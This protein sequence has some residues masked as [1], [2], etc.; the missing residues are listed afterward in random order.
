MESDLNHP[1]I[2]GIGLVTPLGRSAPETWNALMSGRSIG[3]HARVPGFSEADRVAEMAL[4]AANEALG[5]A[6]W[7]EADRERG[8]C[9]LFVGTS[10][11][12]IESWCEPNT[13]SLIH[14][15]SGLEAGLARQLK[16]GP[17]P[18][19]TT[20]SACSSG[21]HA[22]VRAALAI[23]AREAQRVLVVAAEAS[24]QPIFISSFKRLGVLAPEGHGCLPFDANRAGFI[25]SEAAAAICLER[26]TETNRGR[27]MARVDRWAIGADATHLTSGDPYAKALR[28][29]FGRV[30]GAP[31]DL[32]HA[33]AT[34]TSVNDPAEL[35]AIETIA[36]ESRPVLYSHK[37]A[38][39][40]SLGA[41]GLIS[42]VINCLCHIHGRVPANVRST[43]PL[44]MKD[45]QFSNNCVDRRISRS[46]AIAA[47]FGGPLAVVSC[48]N[49]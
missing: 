20:S 29:L 39:G 43:S 4:L 7:M 6:G 41:A 35:S 23:R 10:K 25:I 26:A 37:A 32:I 44:P 38:L 36:G 24:V 34:G 18:R 5:Q 27:V 9:G 40:H 30:G 8:D 28:H 49:P 45:L 11:G 48:S 15:L 22:L 33:H 47:G 12:E 21:L 3:D 2:T 17:G 42:V 31:F 16:F 46:L 13:L 1:V 14:G 19:L